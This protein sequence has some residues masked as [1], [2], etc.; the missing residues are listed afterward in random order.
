[1][2][3]NVG[4]CDRF[5]RVMVGF[6]LLLLGLLL[7]GGLR[8][9]VW[10]LLVAAVGALALATGLSGF[11]LLYVPLGISTA[12]DTHRKQRMW[13]RCGS[14]TGWAEGM[15]GCCAFK[16]GVRGSGAEGPARS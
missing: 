10:G 1:M 16:S 7:F 9:E 11:C 5:M 14:S 2:R 15:S 3:R 12:R 13:A 4:G 8:G 6:A